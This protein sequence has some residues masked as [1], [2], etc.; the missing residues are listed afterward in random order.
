MDNRSF[1]V[2]VTRGHMHDYSVLTKALRTDAHY[3][4]MI[5]SRKKWETQKAQ[6]I[7][8]GFTSEDIARVHTPI[9]LKINA[10]TPEEI[11][12]SIAGEMILSRSKINYY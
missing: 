8:E 4:G 10:E 3:I 9:G 5:G 7:N 2:I 6:L 11:A 1:I 12:I